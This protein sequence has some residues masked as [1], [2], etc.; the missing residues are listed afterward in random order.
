MSAP[1]FLGFI[2][3]DCRRDDFVLSAD[4]RDGAVVRAFVPDPGMALRFPAV[5]D[6]LAFA[7]R[8]DRP[9]WEVVGLFDVGIC[10]AVLHLDAAGETGAD[11]RT[12]RRHRETSA[13][14][15]RR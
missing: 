14:R 6:A 9:D 13:R 5:A 3:L 15:V 8:F 1:V 2:L 10:F 4:E 11:A 7:R 12:R